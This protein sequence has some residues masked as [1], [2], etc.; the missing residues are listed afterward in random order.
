[1]RPT[2]LY[3][4]KKD[5]LSIIEEIMIEKDITFAEKLEL[6]IKLNITEKQYFY[7]DIL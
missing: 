6:K 2:K 7:N 3:T 1:M 4:G 5:L